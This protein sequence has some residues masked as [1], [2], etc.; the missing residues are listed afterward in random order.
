MAVTELANGFHCLAVYVCVC[1]CGVFFGVLTRGALGDEALVQF[2]YLTNSTINWCN[3]S[4][5]FPH[6]WQRPNKLTVTAIASYIY[7]YIARGLRHPTKCGVCKS[8]KRFFAAS[9]AA[10][11][12]E[13]SSRKIV[14]AGFP[15]QVGGIRKSKLW[16]THL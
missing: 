11:Q 7:G 9:S 15:C 5:F 13:V 8:K 14:G 3:Q 4:R 1:V 6:L 2:C 10:K 16:E 12:G